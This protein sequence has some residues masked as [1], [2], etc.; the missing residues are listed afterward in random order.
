MSLIGGLLPSLKRAQKQIATLVLSDPEQFIHQPISVLAERARVS[1]GA[2]V[3]F[4]KSLKLKG[5]PALKI[6]L[7]RDLAEPVFAFTKEGDKPIEGS[8]T[9]Q[10]V[11]Q[12]HVKSLNQT[13]QLT[14]ANALNAAAELLLKARR[15]VLFSIGLSYPVAY[16]LYARLRIIGLPAFIEYDSHLQLAAAAEIGNQDV[17]IAFSL[18]GTTSETVECLRVSRARHA[19]TV[20]VT[21]S[22]ASP[23]ARFADVKLFAA[24]S[25][26][27]YF[28]APLATRVSQL[29]LADALLVVVGQHRKQK[30]LAHLRRAEEH[31]LNRRIK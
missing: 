13:L 12:E 17:A 23:L 14:S 20:C 3:Q 28:Q 29:A 8:S 18:S 6:A 11:F 22:V 31:L 30:A 25:E 10:R 19:K 21:N 4:C 24:P 27:K 26:V 9:L 16:S 2:I 1:A 5:L 7:A 15:I